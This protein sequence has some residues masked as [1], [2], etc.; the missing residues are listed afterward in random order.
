MLSYNSDNYKFMDIQ[1][2]KGLK[3]IL[4]KKQHN[5]NNE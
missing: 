4:S 2:K 1:Q 5:D 3:F